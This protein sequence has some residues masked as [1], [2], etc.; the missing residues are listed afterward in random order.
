MGG[1]FVRNK[2]DFAAVQPKIVQLTLT[3]EP[4]EEEEIVPVV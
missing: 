2:V 3:P 4:L 1:S